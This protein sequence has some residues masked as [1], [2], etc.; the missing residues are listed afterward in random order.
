M[1]KLTDSRKKELKTYLLEHPSMSDDQVGYNIGLAQ[2][3]VS[4]YRKEMN[5]F[6]DIEFVKMTAGVAINKIQQAMEYW[7]HQITKLEELK[8]SKKIIFKQAPDGHKFPEEADLSPMEILAIEKEQANLHARIVY[9]GAQG[10]VRE[11]LKMMR[12]GDI[13]ALIT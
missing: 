11:V 3:T 4:N 1:K 5:L 13:S 7:A 2:S 6:Y 8:S 10:Q 9:L 12:S